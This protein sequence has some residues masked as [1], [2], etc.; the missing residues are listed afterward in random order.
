MTAVRPLRVLVVDDS[1]LVRQ[2]VLSVLAH[3]GFE[4]VTAAD[5]LIAMERMKAAEP[6]VILLDLEM[7]R[8]DGL[9]FLRKIMSE[10][11][12]PVVICSAVAQRGSENALRALEEGAVDIVL[13]PQIGVQQFLYE[14]A[15]T[16]ADAVRGAAQARLLRRAT[17]AVAPARAPVARP[18]PS[19]AE[20]SASVVAIGASTGGTTALRLLLE[21]VDA[22]SPAIVIV[23]HMPRAFTAGFAQGLDRTAAVHVREATHGDT[24][25]RG[26]AL[27][28]PGDSH[29]RIVQR[30]RGGYGVE[31]YSGPLV[32]RHRPSV[33]VMFQS[34]AACY[35]PNA[36][37]I[38]LTGMGADGAVGLEE[39]HRNG[40]FTIAQDEATSVVFGMPREAI[41]RG[42]VDSVLPLQKIAP[43]VNSRKIPAGRA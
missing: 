31:L 38:I 4:I 5:P 21:Q 41:A 30:P 29:L 6:D 43:T 11:P 20:P 3:E 24:L 34:V 22:D 27:L 16:L 25:V 9:S 40:A 10:H 23:Q 17:R 28:A 39:M 7:P 33:D 32:S 8:M 19:A 42:A 26:V 15:V 12:L 14:S 35:G 13:K 37:G 36:I 1:A 2:T 18:F